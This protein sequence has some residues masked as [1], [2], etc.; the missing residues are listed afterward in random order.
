MSLPRQKVYPLLTWRA[1]IVY[2]YSFVARDLR[3]VST[4]SGDFK[5]IKKT[6]L[7]R[8]TVYARGHGLYGRVFHR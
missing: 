2:L 8:P 1:N 4:S 6:T 7:F 5:F 3:F